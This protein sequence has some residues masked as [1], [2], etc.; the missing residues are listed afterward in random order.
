MNNM[1]FNKI[2]AAVLV[3]G[4]VAA[5]SGFI[6]REVVHPHALHENAVAVESSGEPGAGG[7]AAP[8]TAEPILAMIAGADV[9]RGQTLSRACAACHNMD[10][11]G[12]NATGPALWGVVGRGKGTHAG[13]AYSEDMKA[14]GGPWSYADLNTFLWK[15]KALVPGTKM[16][17]VGLKKP[18]DRAALIAWLRTLSDSPVALPSDAEIAAE[19]PEPE[20][21][22]EEGAEAEAAE[23]EK[24]A[25]SH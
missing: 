7:A 1:E 4:V 23:A 19:Q 20:A 8:K 10:K 15:P 13:F 21:I 25:E 24:P 17:F 2:F 22:P 5:L 12:A 18:E 9:A 3:A 6:A 14:K 11:G 16:N